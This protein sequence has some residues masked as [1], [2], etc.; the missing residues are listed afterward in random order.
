MSAIDRLSRD[1]QRFIADTTGH[2][3]EIGIGV[4]LLETDYADCGGSPVAGYFDEHSLTFVVATGRPDARLWLSVYV[5]EYA[6]VLQWAEQTAAWTAKLAGGCCPQEAFDAWLAGVVEMR[7]D[8]LRSA[9]GMVVA[10]EREC[11]EKSVA[12]VSANHGLAID[13]A[14][15]IAAANVHLAY[16]GVVQQ[17]RRWYDRSPYSV[18]GLLELVPDDR[19]F[20][21]DEALA[22]DVG[23]FASI[24]AAC[25]TQGGT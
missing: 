21:V 23:L 13:P 10:C 7:P 24:A 3:R 12:I 2:M 5:H 4:Q 20:T 6:H 16:Y 9:I 17:T 8:Q 15:Y 25:Y 19:V 1:A 11:E 14:W 22:P 18:P